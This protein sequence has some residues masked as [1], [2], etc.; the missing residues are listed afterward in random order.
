MKIYVKK[1]DNQPLI[2]TIIG[3]IIV[4]LMLAPISLFIL[5]L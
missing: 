5:I 4:F 3:A 2:L 1:E